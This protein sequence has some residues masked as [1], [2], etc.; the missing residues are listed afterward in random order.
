MVRQYEDESRGNGQELERFQYSGAFCW[1]GRDE[2]FSLSAIKILLELKIPVF[3]IV[4]ESAVDIYSRL[5]DEFEVSP[6]IIAARRPWKIPVFFDI[7]ETYL[8]INCGFDFIIASDVL[9]RYAVLNLHP[10]YLPYNRG[11]HHSFWGIIERTPLGAT[12]HWMTEELD[13][14]PIIAQEC[15]YDDGEITAEEVQRTS[16]RMCLSLLRKNICRIMSENIKGEIQPPGTYHAK[17]DILTGSK[18]NSDTSVEVRF[19]FDLIRATKVKGHG[20]LIESGG[21][22]YKIV[23]DKITRLDKSADI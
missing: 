12:L 20:F 10:S 18:L 5:R 19:L 15:F 1:V 11:C 3:A 7:P 13:K 9:A 8:G 14:G 4:G 17:K 23:V 6:M 2:E 22:L 21:R 16:N